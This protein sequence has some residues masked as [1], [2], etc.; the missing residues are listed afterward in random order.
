MKILITGITGFLGSHLARFLA[1]YNYK[2]VGIKRHTS[3]TSRLAEI[4]DEIYLYNDSDSLDEIF[5]KHNDIQIIIHAATNYGKNNDAVSDIFFANVVFPLKIIEKACALNSRIFIN[6][7]TF[8]A[9]QNGEYEYLQ[10]YTLSKKIFYKLG[11]QTAVQ[12]GCSFINMQLEHIFGPNDNEDK[13]VPSILR[14]MINNVPEIKF[15]SGEQKR[16]FIY[17]DDVVKAFYTVIKS[18]DYFKRGSV[19]NFEVGQGKTISIRK[20]VEIAHKL[21][22]SK[23]KTIF[24][25]LPYRENEIMFSQANV[26]ALLKL[27]WQYDVNIEK[28]IQNILLTMR[29]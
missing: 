23:S 13:F 1:Q 7:D 21:I 10:N 3:D 18:S 16:D 26:D 24:G 19:Y 11:T 2:L 15:T 22:G 27:G 17:V 4:I 14:S 6:T 20:F 12:K 29:Q 9:K 8:F 28:G 5:K 25:E